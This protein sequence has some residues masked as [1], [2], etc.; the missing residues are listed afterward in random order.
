MAWHN[1]Q[2]RTTPGADAGLAHSGR[3]ARS[4]ARGAPRVPTC[5]FCLSRLEHVLV[6]LGA[7]PLANSYL[8]PADLARMERFYP[9]R[10]YVCENCLLAQ[11]EEFEHPKGIFT[12]YAYFSSYSD[13][14][15]R[16]AERYAAA[17]VGRFGLTADHLVLEIGSNDGYLLQ[18]FNGWGLRIL[19]VDPAANV[20]KVA[21][22]RLVPTLVR[23][24]DDALARELVADG[25][26][27][28][29]L[30]A[31]NVLAHVPNLNEFVRGMKIVLRRPGGVATLEF[32]HLLKLLMN[33]QYDTIYH[34]HFSYF[35]FLTVEKVFAAHGLQIYDVEEIPTHGG[36]LRVYARHDDDDSWPVDARVEDLRSKELQHGMDRLETY[37]GFQD[38]VQRNKWRLVS[39]LIE[40][41]EQGKTVVGYGAPAKANTLLNYCG[42][43]SD[44]LAYTVDR[45]PHKQG[46]YLP[47]TRIPIHDPE[48]L[49]E[50][51]PDYV[52]IL[53]WNLA[54]EIRQK[55]AF[56][57]EWGGRF[58]V[59][60][61]GVQ[62]LP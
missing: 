19:G 60:V 54:E 61:P 7:S 55:A 24:F 17:A 5:R 59:P 47:G 40:A 16:H 1:S 28:D 2:I 35:S 39:F 4:R 50:T 23:F 58:V 12:D 49:R 18:F 34:E 45:S 8:D 13:A 14:F 20:A 21:E 56:V 36:S 10:V 31:N 53:A 32:P 6:D 29:L 15:L 33:V 26:C 62:V 57:E 48:K 11:L 52:L 46:R 41:R 43:R 42:I 25:T 44:L 22:E 9:L 37:Q 51:R 30:I 38:Q 27:A 3:P